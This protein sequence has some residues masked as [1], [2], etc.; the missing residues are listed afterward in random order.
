MRKQKW[1]EEWITEAKRLG[2]EMWKAHYATSDT[3]RE[4]AAKQ[5]DL[6]SERVQTFER[7]GSSIGIYGFHIIQSST[8]HKAS[9]TDLT[10]LSLL[11]ML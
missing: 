6:V 9:A 7:F 11:G 3:D 5:D 2:W 8:V 10:C 1:P 4:E